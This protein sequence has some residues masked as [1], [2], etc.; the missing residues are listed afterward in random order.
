MEKTEKEN[1]RLQWFDDAAIEEKP[2][3]LNALIFFLICVIPVFSAVAYGA[4]DSWALGFLTFV[5]GAIMIFW[6]LEAFYIEEF[7]FNSSSLQIPLLG[8]ITIGLIQLL[9]LRSGVYGDLLSFPAVN[10]LS[11]DAYS[12]RFFVIQLI[13]YFVF[14]AAAL[15]FINNQN[16]L[17]K[18]VLTIIIFGGLMAF[19]GILQRLAVPEAIYG[20]RPTPQAVPFASF[21]N[22]HHFAAFMNMTLGLTLGF[23]FGKGVKK[24]K[25]LLLI[26][27]A[28]IM[29]IALILTSSR[30][31]ILSF[32]GVLGFLTIP[33]IFTKK[34]ESAALKPNNNKSKLLLVAGVLALILGLFG[35]VIMLGGDQSLLRS[36][37]LS[38]P[39]DVSNGRTHFWTIALKIFL[40]YPVLGVG[41]NAF[42]AAFT[43]Y[44]SWNGIFRIEQAHNDYLQILADAGIFGFACVVA[45]IYLLFRKSA[46]I[47]E[48]A[49]SDY[50]KSAARGAL[51]GC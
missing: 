27:A 7:R 39:N 38:N 3:R 10:S 26:I 45:F 6:F 1:G 50:R 30:G 28:S 14:F 17:Q 36:I 29:G 41:L 25:N 2:S 48:T 13:V 43:R 21:V 32:F 49:E 51:A 46:S 35:A 22:Q 5:C 31:G 33:R 19:F 8:L 12:T 20:L 4:V 37:G 9:P 16:R 47:I 34:S 23:L 40:D 11:L 42:G 15:T 44:D 24:D 18:I